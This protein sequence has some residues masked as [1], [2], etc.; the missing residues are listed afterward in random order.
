MSLPDKTNELFDLATRFV[1]HTSRHLFLTGKA[2]TGKTTFLKFI[3]EHCSKKLAVVAPTGVAAI[4]AGGVTMHSFF[5]LPLGSFIP[6]HQGGWNSTNNFNTPVTLFRNLRLNKDKRH[7]MQELELLIIDE[8]SMLRADLLDEM[9]VILRSVRRQPLMPFGGVQLLYIGDLFQLPPVVT[10]EE[11]DVLKDFYRSPF[12]FDAQVMQQAPPLYLE[13]KKIYRQHE[14][15]FIGLLNNIRNNQATQQDL[16]RL[17]Q[18]FRPG[19]EGKQEE[20]YITL[21]THNA[22]ADAINQS[23]LHKLPGNLFEFPAV[24]EGDFNEKSVPAD[25]VLQIKEG[26]QVM[27]IK[28]DRGENRRF[29]NGKIA[30]VTRIVDDEIYVR[31]AGDDDELKVEKE[32]WRNIR[33]R[34]N[35]ESDHIEEEELGTFQQYPIRLAWAITIHKSQ[36]LTFEKAIIDAGASF[37]PGQVYVALSRL[38]SLEGLVLQS[39]IYPHA[40]NTD[41][42][43]LAF[44][45]LEKQTDLLQQEL[46]QEQQIFIARTLVQRF[47]YTKIAERVQDHYEGYENWQLPDQDACVEWARGI[48]NNIVQQKDTGSKFTRQLEQLLPKATEDNYAYLCERV[49]AG[50]DYFVKNME[51][52]IASIQ[53][54]MEE[55]R[56][57]PKVRKYVTAL[58]DLL[59]VCE[60]KKLQVLQAVTIT[61]GLMRGI[62]ANELLNQ[63]QE[64]Q[65]PEAVPPS[66]GAESPTQ[67]ATQEKT[68]VGKKKSARPP[69]GETQRI[70]LEMFNKGI[71]PADIAQQRGLA[72]STIETHLAGFVYTGELEVTRLV[73]EEKIDIIMKAI[74]EMDPSA[75]ALAPLKSKL[76]QEVTYG[77]LKAIMSYRERL[78]QQ[79][80][81]DL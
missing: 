19:Y 15:D 7:L 61:E 21:T 65:R 55:M 33:Y 16:D 8:V 67:G 59:L 5:Q 56:I 70:S 74:D 17:H 71:A 39:K 28:N 18:H 64:E 31:C 11:W 34:Y 73:A 9:D 57:K 76:G 58:K 54:H 48:L 23:Q 3:R 36:G 10:N 79:S 62:S 49:K 32:T 25:M 52:V 81:E 38:T 27:F 50:S 24:I 68:G 42:R 41:E 43:V 20:N 40:I 4:N 63:L 77:E 46:E 2:G 12:F 30:T 29:Y 72:I 78:Q 53:N 51:A 14:A 6:V 75:K 45:R 13:L 80:V 44:T 35:N 47:D 37:A 22:R 26:A 69:K 66:E 1:N 60:R